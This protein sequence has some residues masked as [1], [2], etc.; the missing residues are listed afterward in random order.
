MQPLALFQ[1]ILVSSDL[2]R[3]HQFY[4][5]S[6]HW[7]NVTTSKFDHYYHY[8][9]LH[10]LAHY[11]NWINQ[12]LWCCHFH[13][14]CILERTH[15]SSGPWSILFACG[16]CSLWFQTVATECEVL[17]LLALFAWER[18]A[19]SPFLWSPLCSISLYNNQCQNLHMS[20]GTSCGWMK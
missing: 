18:L 12:I 7:C 4:F 5:Y 14:F 16:S 17:P 19:L 15:V 1:D 11:F 3:S 2:L 6:A 9:Y 10:H 13:Y 20:V 8:H